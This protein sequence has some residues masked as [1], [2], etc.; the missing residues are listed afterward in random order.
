MPSGQV[1]IDDDYD[2]FFHLLSSVF[3]GKKDK[4]S[5]KEKK[6]KEESESKQ[7]HTNRKVK[8]IYFALCIFISVNLFFF[9]FNKQGPPHLVLHPNV[10]SNHILS[11]NLS[12]LH[13]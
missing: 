2:F 4:N 9:F 6:R 11:Y 3:D 8:N 7:D 12:K 13:T 10:W 1:F 5:K